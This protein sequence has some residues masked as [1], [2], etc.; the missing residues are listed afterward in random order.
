MSSLEAKFAELES[1]WLNV[2]NRVGED[3]AGW[4]QQLKELENEEDA[5]RD[6]GRWT[7][8]RD[9]FL[10]VLGRT[11]D[12]LIHS[13]MV[14][15]WLLD[16]C[17]RHGLGTQVLKEI[18][19]C[20][21]GTACDV[22][23]LERARVRREKQLVDGCL[24]IVVNAPGLHLVIENKVDAEEGEGQCA[25]YS[26]H[27]PED[28]LC[29]LLSPDGRTPKSA[30]QDADAEIKNKFQPLRYAKLVEILEQALAGATNAA[31]GRAVAEDYLK[32]L[33]KEFS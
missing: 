26:R 8:G 7:H 6:E 18:I 32:T 24:D 4:K 29:I 11:R 17:A 21:F 22:S 13:Q 19:H 14:V 1:E 27:L 2:C 5:L 3:I 20:V 12:E 25:Y 30:A 10:G 15:A 31:S 33:K 9:D 28:A 23:G 16:P